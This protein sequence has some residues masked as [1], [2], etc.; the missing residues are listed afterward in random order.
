MA[1]VR[2]L[3][4]FLK[5]GNQVKILRYEDINGGPRKIP[6]FDADVKS[7]KIELSEKDLLKIDLE[8]KQVFLQN[9]GKKIELGRQ[10]VYL[11]E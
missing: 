8:S 3:D 5:D 9:N 1:R 2:K 11:V 7:D 6:V 10:M 4:R